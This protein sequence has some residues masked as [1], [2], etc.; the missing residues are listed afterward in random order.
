MSFEFKARL[1]KVQSSLG[2]NHH[3]VV[4]LDVSEKILKGNRRVICEINNKISFQ[5]GLF[6]KGKGIYFINM[7]KQNRDKLNVV[8]GDELIIKL[9]EDTSKYGIPIPPVF[10][11][12]LIQDPEGNKRFHAQTAGV[13]RSLLYIIAKPKN[14]Q[15]RL[16]KGL[17]ILDYLKSFDGKVDFKGL[18]EA[19]R[20]SRLK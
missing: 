2:W 12:L 11:E 3:F 20:N 18:I 13:Q 14:E 7:N 9:S 6:P 16:E 15:L 4:P 10:E 19:L 8:D 1:E 17:I 5:C